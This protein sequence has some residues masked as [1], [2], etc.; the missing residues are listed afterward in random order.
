VKSGQLQAP[1]A[2]GTFLA[3]LALGYVRLMRFL[4]R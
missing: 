1:Y 2:L 4:V 3:L